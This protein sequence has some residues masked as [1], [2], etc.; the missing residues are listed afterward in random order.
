MGRRYL[1]AIWL[2][3]VV[4]IACGPQ[5][6]GPPPAAPAPVQQPAHLL[7]PDLDLAIRLDLDELRGRFG[8][9]FVAALELPAVAED[10]PPARALVTSLLR[11]SS[12][13]WFAIRPPGDSA[14]GPDALDNV[15]VLRGNYREVNPR[16]FAGENVW[17]AP[18]DLGGDWRRYSRVALGRG[19]PE[20]LYAYGDHLRVLLSRAEIDSMDALLRGRL[21]TEGLR[22]PA[23]GMASIALRSAAWGNALDAAGV[24]LRWL[25]SA[26]S[27][28]S[29]IVAEGEGYRMYLELNYAD[30]ESA[31]SAADQLSLA[32]LLLGQRAGSFGPLLKAVD[33][34]AA[35]TDVLAEVAVSDAQGAALLACAFGRCGF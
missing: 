25:E 5:P 6:I 30:K 8:S 10:D 11:Q 35:E 3:F 24:P 26:T 23:R 9:D 22:P 21:S 33:V 31:H 4:L 17:Q 14:R 12:A 20:R 19:G 13:L 16:D 2:G 15:L 18:V 29:R 28:R 7:P 1:V 32:L 34:K 27:A